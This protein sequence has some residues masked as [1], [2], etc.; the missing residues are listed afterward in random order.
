MN[1]D[2][3]DVESHKVPREIRRF[4]YLVGGLLSILGGLSWW[5]D[6]WVPW[7]ILLVPGLLIV[8]LALLR[9]PLLLPVHKGWMKFARVLGWIQIHLLLG[10]LFYLVITPLGWMLRLFGHDPLAK[11][12]RQA[13]SYWEP[14]ESSS[15]GPTRYR[16]QY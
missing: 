15:S 2:S 13:D 7:P 1:R 16:K 10:L 14:H 3:R 9:S 8:I 4:G 6:G 11:K 5:R 12:R